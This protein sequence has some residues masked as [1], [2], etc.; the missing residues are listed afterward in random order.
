[1]RLLPKCL[2]KLFNN[3]IISYSILVDVLKDTQKSYR[4][5]A[6]TPLYHADQ[7]GNTFAPKAGIRQEEVGGVTSV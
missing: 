3:G 1:M 7:L 4:F 2:V 5:R 6:V